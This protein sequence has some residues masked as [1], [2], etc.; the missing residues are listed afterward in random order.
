MTESAHSE[1]TIKKKRPCPLEPSSPVP[2]C[3]PLFA[4]GC[5]IK[6]QEKLAELQAHVRTGKKGTAC[7]KK[8]G[9]HRMLQ[10]VIKNKQTTTSALLTEVQSKQYPWL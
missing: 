10:Q 3:T 5:M 8:K 7:R 1:A 4:A 2:V 6:N 9:V